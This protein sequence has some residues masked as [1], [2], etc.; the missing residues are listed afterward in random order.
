[1]SDTIRSPYSRDAFQNL[2]V[3]KLPDNQTGSITPADV[4]VIFG[5]LA[6]ST[7]W[8]DETSSGA[9]AFDVAVAQGF[10]GDTTAWLASLIGPEGPVG[11]AGPKGDRGDA[12]VAGEPGPVGP[13]GPEGPQGPQ[14]DKGDDGRTVA[15]VLTTSDTR[16]LLGA[17]YDGVVVT[18]AAG[19][20]T[21]FV[22]PD[23][24]TAQIRIG[25][26]VHVIQGGEGV[27]RFVTDGRATM[28][29]MADF[30][31]ETRN[32][33]GAISA[34]KVAPDTW[35]IHGD[36]ALAPGFKL[37]ANGGNLSGVMQVAEREIRLGADH[38][39][40]MIET[41]SADEVVVIVTSDED[42]PI[43]TVVHVVQ[44]GDG[45]V[46]FKADKSA[47]LLHCGH[48]LPEGSGRHGV[49]VLHKTA[50]ATWRASG[51]LALVRAFA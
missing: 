4:R 11:P 49:V 51:D 50:A 18:S 43:G 21:D 35:R 30:V 6:D 48:R 47:T 37:L 1:M 9:S 28:Q 23:D 17:E 8:H 25:A 13:A 24:E 16:V 45:T 42:L 12:G 26:I 40:V 2:V 34:L 7:L 33:F 22:L 20:T 31:P 19:K 27:A 46:R 29:I 38:D 10:T 15:S 3:E 36:A 41:M 14:G 5:G 39:G 44:S 32:R